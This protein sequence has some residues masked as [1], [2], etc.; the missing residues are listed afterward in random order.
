MELHHFSDASTKGYGQCTYLRLVDT[1]HRIHCSLVMGKSR[2]APMKITTIPRL[3]LTA[4]LVS[5]RV[6]NMVKAELKCEEDITDTY[7]TDSKVVLG[8]IANEA[9]RFQVFVGNRVQAIRNKTQP[10][11]WRHVRS[12]DNPADEASRGVNSEELMSTSKWLRGPDF[13]WKGEIPP[14][15][16]TEYK[17]FPED[18]EV[19]KSVPLMTNVMKPPEYFLLQRLDHL[20]RLD[21]S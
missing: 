2:V 20:S 6:G 19:K 5:A 21:K 3:E 16:D 11:Q 1:N 10:S 8:Y 9:R 13:L 4:A 18:P 17:T 7:W 12:E 14:K 15:A